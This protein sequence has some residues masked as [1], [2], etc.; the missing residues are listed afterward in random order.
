MR[1]R[2]VKALLG[3]YYLLLSFWVGTVC[4]GSMR[5]LIFFHQM[6]RSLSALREVLDFHWKLS[7]GTFHWANNKHP[8]HRVLPVTVMDA[9]T[10]VFGPVYFLFDW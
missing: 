2:R 10:C 6:M 4:A 8:D 5:F 1:H 9:V 7:S 3:S